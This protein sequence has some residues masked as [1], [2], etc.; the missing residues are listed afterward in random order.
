MTSNPMNQE[1]YLVEIKRLL[2]GLELYHLKPEYV[3]Y[4]LLKGHF[5][6]WSRF[7]TIREE[8]IAEAWHE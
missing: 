2:I 3:L 6:D 5:S 8:L 4:G 1:S 7:L